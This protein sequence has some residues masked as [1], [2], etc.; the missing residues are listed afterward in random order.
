VK[1]LASTLQERDLNPETFITPIP[2]QVIELTT[3]FSG[4][5]GLVSLEK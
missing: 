5:Y 1:E 3:P 2:G 4:R